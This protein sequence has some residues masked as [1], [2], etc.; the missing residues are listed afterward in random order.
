M[1]PWSRH[2]QP[3][4]GSGST[5][6]NEAASWRER[7]LRRVGFEADLAARTA[8]DTAID[9]HALIGLVERGCPPALAVRIVAPLDEERTSC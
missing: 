5:D 3:P 2:L 1:K 6:R 4:E 9:L 7:Q 8:A